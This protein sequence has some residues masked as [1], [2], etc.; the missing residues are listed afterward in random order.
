MNNLNLFKF[1]A[2]LL[3]HD[4]CIDWCKEHNLLASSVKCPRT[5]CSNALSW[6]RRASSRDGYEWRYSKRGCDGMASMRRN[7]WFSG[8]KLSIEKA[9]A[10]TYAWAHKFSNTQAVHECSLDEET[11]SAETVVDWYNYCRE[12]CAD[13]TDHESSC[14]AYRWTWAKLLRLT[15]PSL[16][17]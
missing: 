16:A 7:S 11:T 6:T 12:V 14:G 9:L 15:S 13:R 4:R 1:S 8:S 17:R 10:L 3:D 5:G 2:I